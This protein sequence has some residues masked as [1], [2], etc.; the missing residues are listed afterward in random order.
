MFGKKVSDHGTWRIHVS[1]HH[2]LLLGGKNWVINLTGDVSR[3]R[4]GLGIRQVSGEEEEEEGE[5][6]GRTK[7]QNT[8]VV[9]PPVKSLAEGNQ[10]NG[11]VLHVTLRKVTVDEGDGH[12]GQDQQ[13]Q[14]RDSRVEILG[15]KKGRDVFTGVDAVDKLDKVDAE[16][17]AGD[18]EQLTVEDVTQVG[19]LATHFADGT[20][21]VEHL[22][23]DEQGEC[24][25]GV[26]KSNMNFAN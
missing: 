4:L 20:S 7:L 2:H 8:P 26:L 3:H 18:Q 23:E 21:I 6:L 12:Q 9:D 11:P 22:V 14:L 1:V 24:Q 13:V 10:D 15:L 5:D 17:Q 16:G 19:I 25:G